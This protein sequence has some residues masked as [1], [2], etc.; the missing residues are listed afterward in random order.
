ML[1]GLSF[2]GYPLQEL[3][4]LFLSAPLYFFLTTLLHCYFFPAASRCP[5]CRS[6][7]NWSCGPASSRVASGLSFHRLGMAPWMLRSLLQQIISRA[8]FSYI[9]AHIVLLRPITFWKNLTAFT[10][11]VQSY[12]F[13]RRSWQFHFQ[14]PDNSIGY[15]PPPCWTWWCLRAGCIGRWNLPSRLHSGKG[16]T[17]HR[18]S[19]YPDWGTFVNS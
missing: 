7:K 16:R 14:C 18:K 15:W 3:S 19:K 10:S 1:T 8:S 6:S 5:R 17:G 9:R 11:L 2:F 4:F 12:G 13:P